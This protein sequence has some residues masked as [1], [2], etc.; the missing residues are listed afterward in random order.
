M[1][2]SP[3]QSVCHTPSLPP[4][5]GQVPGTSPNCSESRWLLLAPS[6]RRLE[7]SPSRP[8]LRRCPTWVIHV[9][10]AIS[11]CPTPPKSGHSANAHDEGEN[12]RGLTATDTKTRSLNQAMRTRFGPSAV[13]GYF[14]QKIIQEGLADAVIV[15]LQSSVCFASARNVARIVAARRF[16]A[17]FRFSESQMMVFR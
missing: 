4:L 16:S 10:P 11:A 7:D 6:V 15:I 13:A 3:A 17:S 5:G 12:D 2:A 9:I 14:G 8:H 1:A